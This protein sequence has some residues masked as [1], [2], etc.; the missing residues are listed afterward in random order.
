MNSVNMQTTIDYY[1]NK[2]AEHGAGA[3]GMDWKDELSQHLRFDVICR[4]I[5]FS[6]TPSVLDVG[7]GSG[8]FLAYCR[9][10]QLQIS[11]QGIDICPEM[12]AACRNRFG[13]AS[14]VH[15]ASE[16]LADWRE[17]YDY[18]IASGTFNA[19]LAEK[20]DVWKDYFYNNLTAMFHVCRKATIVNMMTCFVDYRYDRLY[21]PT[22]QEIGDFAV[23]RLERRFH[24][25]HSYPLYEMT[26]VFYKE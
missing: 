22:L 17:T 11:Y 23:N 7:C 1:Q 13:E 24:I 5:D 21:Y 8:E 18:V 20:D 14:A 16:Q 15:T 25:D 26:V 2:L 3:E 12:V 9:S 4:Y 6:G 19:K 10:R